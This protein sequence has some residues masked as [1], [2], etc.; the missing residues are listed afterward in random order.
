MKYLPLTLDQF[1]DILFDFQRRGGGDL[2]VSFNADERYAVD[3]VI[4]HVNS[5]GRPYLEIYG[6]KPFDDGCPRPAPT[7]QQQK[8]MGQIAQALTKNSPFLDILTGGKFPEKA[9]EEPQR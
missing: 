9:G 5:E 7:E 1:I 4:F 3:R 6:D 2:P 8:I